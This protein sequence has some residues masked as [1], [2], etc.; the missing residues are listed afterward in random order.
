MTADGGAGAEGHA[1]PET[2]ATE[3]DGME[4]IVPLSQASSAGGDGGGGGGAAA[5]GE[6]AKEEADAL[7]SLMLRYASAPDGSFG[8]LLHELSLIASA[9]DGATAGPVPHGE[10]VDLIKERITASFED[11]YLH[12]MPRC[13]RRVAVERGVAP[14][15]SPSAS[16]T[17]ATSGEIAVNVLPS[18]TRT[19][20]PAG[21]AALCTLSATFQ[22][23]R[24]ARPRR[25][26]TPRSTA[27]TPSSAARS[28]SSAHTPP[29]RR[30]PPRAAHA[31][32]ALPRALLHGRLAPRARQRL[33][34]AARRDAQ[35][36]LAAPP[37][38]PVA[39]ALPRRVPR[40][41]ATPGATPRGAR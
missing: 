31:R 17:A 15:G 13:R 5:L 9:R 7:L 27:S 37:A 18:S 20:C 19:A 21:G 11:E 8:F 35:K 14:T 10:L 33:L 28:T 24:G 26:R 6:K 4:T 2:E 25:A 40:R 12:D 16:T 30:R 1:A 23:L 38:A 34:H 36:G 32:G 22:L 39:R 41:D 29:R 3:G